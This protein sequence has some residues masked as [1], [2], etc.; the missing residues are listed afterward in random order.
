MDYLWVKYLHVTCVVLSVSLFVLR[1]TLE[2]MAQ[3][4]RQWRLL[5]VAPHVIDTLLLTSALWLA[6]RIGQYPFVHGW[7]T[8]KVLALLA[9]ILLGMR[10]LG[11]NTSPGQRLP[12]FVAA[13]LSVGYIVGVAL[14]HS[15]SWGFL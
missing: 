3:P 5:K 8:A 1:G 11:K 4:W 13:L 12:Y 10:A 14:T 6:W 7:L 9:Y 15:P 2:L